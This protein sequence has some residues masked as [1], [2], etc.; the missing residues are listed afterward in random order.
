MDRDSGININVLFI[1]FVL[2]IKH[3]YRVIKHEDSQRNVNVL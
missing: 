1:V 2:R 3:C